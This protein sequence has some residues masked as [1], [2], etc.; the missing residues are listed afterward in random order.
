M[1]QDKNII[2]VIVTALNF[3]FILPEAINSNM[4]ASHIPYF[5]REKG[6][7][8]IGAVHTVKIQKYKLGLRMYFVFS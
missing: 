4:T 5:I 8:Y 6:R 3:S 7:R 2:Y 1:A